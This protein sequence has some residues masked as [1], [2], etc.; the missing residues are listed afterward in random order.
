MKPFSQNAARTGRQHKTPECK[1][2]FHDFAVRLLVDAPRWKFVLPDTGDLEIF[3][4][5]GLSNMGM[6]YDNPVKTACDVISTHLGINDRRFVGGYQRKVKVKRGNEFIQFAI[7]EA[8]SLEA[9]AD[10][11]GIEVCDR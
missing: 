9:W 3:F 6:D 4:V 10:L 7:R 2:F 5:W 8:I 11:T 1:Q